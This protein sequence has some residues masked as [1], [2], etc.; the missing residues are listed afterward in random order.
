MD[1]EESLPVILQV[2]H[3]IVVGAEVRPVGFCVEENKNL[4]V[5]L[6]AQLAAGLYALEDVLAVLVELELLDD[7]LAG[8]DAK[9]DALARGL[10]TGDALDVD[11]VLEPVDGDDLA[12]AALVGTS[13]D[14]DLIVLS[15]GDAADLE[16]DEC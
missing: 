8:V 11:L 14:L 7:N 9:G 10:V 3:T 12:L 5:V 13:N 1:E 2:R 4:F 6:L 15:D 16:E